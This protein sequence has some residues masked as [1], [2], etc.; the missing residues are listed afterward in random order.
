MTAIG[1]HVI[2]AH[3]RL[4]G[5]DSQGKVEFI[6][7]HK[8]DS[9]P[10]LESWLGAETQLAKRVCAHLPTYDL[11]VHLSVPGGIYQIRRVPLEVAEEVDRQSQV[12]W[13]VRQALCAGDGEYSVEYTVRGSSAIW[14]AIPTACVE[15]MTAAFSI[16][17]VE[18]FGLAAEP[19]G[20]ARML[21]R[22]HAIGP[23][24]AILSSQSWIST[25]DLFDGTL[26]A[27]T[28]RCTDLSGGQN[29]TN[30]V[31]RREQLQKRIAETSTR[32]YLTGEE[33][34]LAELLPEGSEIRPLQVID[35]DERP[36][37]DTLLSIAYGVALSAID[38]DPL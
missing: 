35:A 25:V 20:V 29:Q 1:I 16:Q 9:G 10:Y 15:S 28:T 4:C 27:A 18:L 26:I 37:S 22:K 19:I 13:E 5:I 6:E 14:V 3:I 17:G 2:A 32:T 34:N 12:A 33:E 7:S 31:G 38:E 36:V 8:E 23:A 11:P 30:D 21:R 24:R